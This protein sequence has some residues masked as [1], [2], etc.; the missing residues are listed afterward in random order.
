MPYFL[1]SSHLRYMK[2]CIVMTWYSSLQSSSLCFATG[3]LF[4]QI[5]VE[6]LVNNTAQ[7]LRFRNTSNYSHVSPHTS[8]IRPQTDVVTLQQLV[9]GG[10]GHRHSAVS[11]GGAAGENT[12][13]QKQFQLK[14]DKK[15]NPKPEDCNH[16]NCNG[17]QRNVRAPETSQWMIHLADLSWHL[18]G[19][20]TMFVSAILLLSIR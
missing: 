14:E 16:L 10:F 17:M 15:R 11:S 8:K 12:E 3:L 6:W 13:T 4:P 7:T 5:P 18:S 2:R 20:K 19:E 9:H 1:G